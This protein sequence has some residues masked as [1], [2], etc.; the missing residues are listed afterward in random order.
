MAG[1]FHADVTTSCANVQAFAVG[2]LEIASKGRY[3][4]SRRP[5]WRSEIVSVLAQFRA[6]RAFRRD[7]WSGDELILHCRA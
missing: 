7:P 4:M 6:L 1:A 5:A 3:D 2:S